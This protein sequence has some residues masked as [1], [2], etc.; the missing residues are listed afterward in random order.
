[1]S[2][3]KKQAELLF[4]CNANIRHQRRGLGGCNFNLLIPARVHTVLLPSIVVKNLA[5]FRQTIILIN[6]F[7]FLLN[8]DTLDTATPG[9]KT[10]CRQEGKHR[11]CIRSVH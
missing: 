2:M 7:K 9:T 6:I 11:K 10:R 1:M 3:T 4:C 5:K 8:V